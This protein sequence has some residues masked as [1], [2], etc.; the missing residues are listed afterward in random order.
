MIRRPPRSTLFP[1]TTLFRSL[2][3]A[4]ASASIA[5]G[6]NRFRTL[7]IPLVRA[8]VLEGRVRR[9]AS[10]GAGAPG[11][12]SLG[13]THRRPGARRRLSPLS[14]GGLFL[15]GGQPGGYQPALD[16]RVL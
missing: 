14:G 13:L 15:L 11:G 1:Y 9:A 4:F 12:G 8:G 3:P 5:P 7:D 10:H 2:V 16:A 6:P